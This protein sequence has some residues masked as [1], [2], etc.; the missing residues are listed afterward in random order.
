MLRTVRALRYVMPFR[1][2]GSVPALVEGD[3]LGLYVVKLRGAAQGTKALVAE[4]VA[5]ELARAVGLAVPEIVLVEVDRV[6]ARS[7]PDPELSAP[8]EASAGLN[9]GLDYLPGSITFDSIVGPPPDAA[10][11]SLI[12]L[13]DAFVMNVDRTPRNPNL[14]SW[15]RR[16]WLI[17]HGASLYFHHAWGPD[18]AL[19]GTRDPFTE[20]RQHVLW[21]WASALTD[22]AVRL[23]EALDG[24]AIGRVVD[25][26]PESWLGAEH[27]FADA[28]AHRAAYVAWL[29]ERM[30]SMPIFLKG[31]EHGR[32]LLV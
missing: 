4:L 16:L 32:T 21:P 29:R 17:D 28:A 9:V 22:A 18:H 8:L 2:G 12:V 27:G 25:A 24:Q 26:I 20:A 3:D 19:D 15:H 11:A 7:E 5:G 30:A 31:A 10:T 14:L 6:L 23:R 1:E 13:F